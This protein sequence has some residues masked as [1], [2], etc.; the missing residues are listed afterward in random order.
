MLR[1][2]GGYLW[3]MG[4]YLRA[5]REVGLR[6]LPDRGA[7]YRS[8]RFKRA[9][10]RVVE[11]IHPDRMRLKVIEV[12]DE[13]PTTRTLRFERVD[14]PLPPFRAG[15]YVNLFVEI[16]GVRT[17]RPYSISSPPGVDHLD[18]TIKNAAGGFVAPY[19]VER[20]KVGEELISTG[21]AGQLYHEPLIHTDSLVF[22][23]AGS[24]V[25]P[26]MSMIRHALRRE[27]FQKLLLLYGCRTP[28]EVIFGDELRRLA[29]DNEGLEV[30]ITL[31]APPPDHN[32][33]KGRLS[34]ELIAA[35]VG[36]PRG[37]TVYVCGPAGLFEMAR[38]TLIGMGVPSRRIRRES[39]GPPSPI[40]DV[41][42]WPAEV[43]AD[44]LF[45][46]EVVGRVPI[47]AVAGEPLLNTLERHGLAL[48]ALCRT[49]ACSSC[50]VQLIEGDVYHSPDARVRQ[51]DEA[52]GV[53]HACVTYPLSDLKIRL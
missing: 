47:P 26:F 20:V 8:D 4:G 2:L 24:G 14:G 29:A 19:V 18:L 51:S 27:I 16:D 3:D 21:P 13:T 44:T 6:H 34:P 39:Y 38:D 53:V 49:G 15:Q 9:A 52:R 48:P 46:V 1:E 43:T 31:S 32:G 5:A 37:K 41:P 28:E 40:S 25:T 7:D 42:G 35:R 10:R 45:Q 17:S 50:R 11:R 36:D 33:P 22:I 23:A 12:I 30:V